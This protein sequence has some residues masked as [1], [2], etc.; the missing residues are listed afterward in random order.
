MILNAGNILLVQLKLQLNTFSNCLPPTLQLPD[1]LVKYCINN[2]MV[3]WTDGSIDNDKIGC[4]ILWNP[5]FKT[6]ESYSYEGPRTSGR[7]EVAAIAI[8]LRHNG[9]EEKIYYSLQIA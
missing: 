9:L 3:I 7:A 8:A 6:G 1:N 4:G 2:K 5:L